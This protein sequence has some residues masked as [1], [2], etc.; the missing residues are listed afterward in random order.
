MGGT[1]GRIRLREAK[2][3]CG[4]AKHCLM[5]VRRLCDTKKSVLGQKTEIKK[6]K[7]HTLGRLLVEEKEEE[8]GEL[9]S[10]EKK[11][12]QKN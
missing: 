12:S 9:A 8:Q 1:D 3:E 7:K 6:E 2:T 11:I 5:K 10:F 4:S